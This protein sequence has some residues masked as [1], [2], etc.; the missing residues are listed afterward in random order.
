MFVALWSCSKKREKVTVTALK[1]TTVQQSPSNETISLPL[2]SVKADEYTGQEITEEYS[3]ENS[4]FTFAGSLRKNNGDE[5]LISMY[6]KALNG[7]IVG[8]YFYEA[9]PKKEDIVLKGH[10]A[11]DSLM[12]TEYDAQNKITGRFSGSIIG[13]DTF[14]G[15]WTSPNNKRSLFF[16]LYFDD[17]DYEQRKIIGLKSDD[18]AEADDEQN[19]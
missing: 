5:I 9:N 11:G 1:D 15:L 14:E 2:G 12:L 6:L 7:N 17:M 13:N 10:I 8:K 19:L 3:R 16:K 4:D 18:Y